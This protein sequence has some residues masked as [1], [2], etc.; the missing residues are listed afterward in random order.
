MIVTDA[1]VS[2]V[3]FKVR[4]RVRWGECDPAGVVYTPVFGEYVI[5]TAELFYGCLLGDS[6]Q[7]AKSVLGFGTPTRAMDFD[8]RISLRPD[9]EIDIVVDVLYI[10]EHTFRLRMTA[11]KSESEVAFVAHLV[12]VCVAR[13]ERRSIPVPEELRKAL[14][15]YRAQT[16][17]E[18]TT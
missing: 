5:A 7:R 16:S 11:Y 4:R 10:R 1:I 8:F 2:N 6:P 18:A 14:E 15:L 12:P 17:P 9:D 13:S 3:P